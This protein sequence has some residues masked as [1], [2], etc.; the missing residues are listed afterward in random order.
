[1]DLREKVFSAIEHYTK[2]GGELKR[3]NPRQCLL[4]AIGRKEK[5][6]YM[7]AA[8]TVLGITHDQAGALEAGFEDWQGASFAAY[9]EEWNIGADIA[10]FYEVV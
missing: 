4:G 8:A 7:T 5:G 1:M 10:A 9:P 3:G 6:P 2:T